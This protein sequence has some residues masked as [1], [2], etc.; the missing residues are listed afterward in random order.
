MVVVVVV[1]VVVVLELDDDEDEE[2]DAPDT[3]TVTFMLLNHRLLGQ[4]FTVAVQASALV[5]VFVIVQPNMQLVLCSAWLNVVFPV[6]GLFRV[7]PV[8]RLLSPCIDE[9][10]KPVQLSLNSMALLTT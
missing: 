5:E 4:P 9:T 10:E 7:T 8:Q 6:V 3:V 1:V 2:L